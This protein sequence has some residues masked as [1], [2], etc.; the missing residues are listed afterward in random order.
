MCTCT[1]AMRKEACT[2][3]KSCENICPAQ[4]ITMESDKEGFWYP[5]LNQG[6]CRQCGACVNACPVLHALQPTGAFRK[7]D[8]EKTKKISIYA[9]WSLDE[10]IRYHSTSGGIFSEAALSMLSDGGYVCGAVYGEDCMVKHAIING[11][12]DLA[13][14]RQSKYVQSDM[15][16]IYH[17]IGDLLKQGEKLLFCGTPC[18]CAGLFRYCIECG[19]GTGNLYLMDFICRGANSPKVYRK[20]LD[21]LEARY[22]SK[23]KRVWFKNKTYGWN[24]FSTKIEFENG[25]AYLQD[26]YH[27]AYIRGYIEENLFMRPSCAEC[28]FKGFHRFSDLMLADFWGV[29]LGD[30]SQD[31]DGGI[32]LVAVCTEKGRT[33]WDSMS[34][35][36]YK[37]EK[38]LQEAIPGN[39][40]FY[41]SAPQGIGRKQFMEDL[42]KMSV[43]DN[44]MRFLKKNE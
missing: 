38:G 9:A 7:S 13:K 18:Q 39:V 19:V 1:E 30:A 41:H 34:S 5:S 20:F 28:R 4:A 11:K 24:R 16:H 43:I 35:R 31:A 26:R 22:R 27:D 3:C 14:L 12:K 21:E 23:A 10:E 37:E 44:M 29:R 15:G 42:D 25:D 36:I 2:G 17:E 40:C 8:F 6:I 33:L 32:S